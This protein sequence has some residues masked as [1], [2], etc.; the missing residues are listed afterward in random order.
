MVVMA[1]IAVSAIVALA[2]TPN[3]AQVRDQWAVERTLKRL[4]Y[5]TDGATAIV[6]F[7]DDVQVYPGRLSH[8]SSLITTD[9]NDLCG[10]AYTQKAVD[11]WSGR[12]A[13]RLYAQAGTPLPLGA[14]Q[15]TLAYED[16]A[17]GGPALVVVL[18]DVREEQAVRFYRKVDQTMD[19]AT[20]VEYSAADPQ[21]LVTLRW[22]KAIAAC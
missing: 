13:G 21:G 4:T 18:E 22:R 1:L 11:D 14:M 9:Q 10:T 17:G 15:D 19:A 16:A 3:V 20:R 12:Y 5:L 6:R 8:L 7:H 2:V